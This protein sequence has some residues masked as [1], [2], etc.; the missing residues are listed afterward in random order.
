MAWVCSCSI[1]PSPLVVSARVS[2]CE[3]EADHSLGL[4]QGCVWSIRSPFGP[5]AWF[6]SLHSGHPGL[7]S[8]KHPFGSDALSIRDAALSETWRASCVASP[9]AS[10]D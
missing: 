8:S 7:A 6:A 9:E 1:Y 2:Y 4:R 3:V 10:A 5:L